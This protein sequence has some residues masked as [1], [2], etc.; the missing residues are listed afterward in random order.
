[1]KTDRIDTIPRVSK[2]LQIVDILA[3]SDIELKTS[4]L[5]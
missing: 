2:A 1:M 3:L 4:L 5:W